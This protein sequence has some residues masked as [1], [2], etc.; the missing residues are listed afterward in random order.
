MNAKRRGSI[1]LRRK[2][3][4]KEIKQISLISLQTNIY[5]NICPI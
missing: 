3:K 4:F 1:F 2:N 5:I